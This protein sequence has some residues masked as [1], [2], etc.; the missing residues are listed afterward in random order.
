MN[1]ELYHHGVKYDKDKKVM[2]N[3]KTDWHIS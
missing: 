2:I 3:K 1:N